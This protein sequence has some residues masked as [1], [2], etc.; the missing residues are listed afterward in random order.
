MSMEHNPFPFASLDDLDFAHFLNTNTAIHNFPLSVLDTMIYKPFNYFQNN[1]HV[2]DNLSIQ[3]NVSELC[4]DYI[5]SDSIKHDIS[6]LNLLAF[7]ISS[8]PRHL[9]SCVDQ[10]VNESQVR[11]DV[12]AFCET[13]LNDVICSIYSI[14]GYES[15]FNNKSTTGGG[16][17]IYV[18]SN[19]DVRTI[20]N[21][22]LQL[23]DIECLFLEIT[24][25][26]Q[27][28]VGMI[29]R[30]PNSDAD[31]FISALDNIITTTLTF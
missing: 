2:S 11:C 27:F 1:N 7:N 17:A 18:N 12:L 13:R 29:Y 25:P 4:C 22:S 15:Y 26:E 31:N 8:I 21:L 5:F 6:G 30:P 14:E 24:K 10:C 16:L 3:Y 19:F 23:P 20:C 28:L 9:D